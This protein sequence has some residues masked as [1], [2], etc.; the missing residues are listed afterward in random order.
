MISPPRHLDARDGSRATALGIIV[1]IYA[2]HAIDRGIVSVVLEPMRRDLGLDDVQAGVLG[3]LAYG[4][5]YAV[6][7]IPMGIMVDRLNR[8]N[9]LSAILTIWS[10]MTLLAGFVQSYAGLV[11]C[12]AAVGAAESGGGPTSISLV[13]DLYRPE[14]RARALGLLY[15]GSGLGAA[16][17]AI[18]GGWIARQYG[19]QIA[20]IAAGAPG[21]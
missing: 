13:S 12:R 3:G 15:L 9:L 5:A 7:C 14:E 2:V 10:A 1:L 18:V 8:R 4:V 16:A 21:C 6:T 19:W 17:A 11:A 20:L